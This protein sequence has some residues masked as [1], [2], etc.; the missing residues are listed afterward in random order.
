MESVISK[1]REYFNSGE[2]LS[3]QFRLKQLKL[4]KESMANH[5]DDLYKAF[6]SDRNLIYT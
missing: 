6:K 1:Q 4:L 3:I 5:K 2:T